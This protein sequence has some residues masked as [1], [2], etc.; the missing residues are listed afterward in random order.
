MVKKCSFVLFFPLIFH[1]DPLSASEINQ[2]LMKKYYNS[3]LN[4]Q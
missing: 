2:T 4:V 1:H 3:V